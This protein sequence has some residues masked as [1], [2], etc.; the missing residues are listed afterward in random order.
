LKE[1]GLS[2]AKA[3][4]ISE[5]AI[6]LAEK[7]CRELRPLWNSVDNLVFANQVRVLEAFTKERISSAHMAPTTGYGYQDLGRE[8][9]ERLYARIFGAESALVRLH[10]ASGTHVLKTALSAL[11][12]PGEEL[13]ALTGTPYETL[14]PVIH[15]LSE[16]G[17]SYRET[18]ILVD[19]ETGKAD[20]QSLEQRLA[21]EI[22]PSTKVLFIQRSRG[23]SL[24][25]SISLK[26]LRSL[27][28]IT[29]KR[30]PHLFT[31]VDNCYCE[32]VDTAEPPLL[33]AT[34]TLGSLIKNPGGGLAPTGGYVAGKRDA[35]E[36]VAET[37][38][39]PGLSGQVGSNPYG[40]R[41]LYQ[42]LFLAPKV[43]GEALRGA[44]FAALFFQ[45]M[46]Y[47]VDPDPFEERT[48][49]VQSITLNS[50]E[51]LK[52]LTESVQKASPVDSFA[53]PVPWDMPGY[54]HQV[55]MAAGTFIQGSSIELSCDAPFA[56]PYTAYL[57][58]GLTK[59][60]VIIACMAAFDRLKE[61]SLSVH[62]P[63]QPDNLP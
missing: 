54:S 59:E 38:Y 61:M 51:G 63:I 8:G 9:L 15:S 47:P 31:V 28:A 45:K 12:R 29:E 25:K 11:L 62:I 22:Q 46:G 26:T 16:F 58:G 20:Q 56:P 43:V 18:S 6:D 19:F 33:G 57:Q 3:L 27:F 42:G 39:A 53:V 13:L 48:D 32:L 35:V 23:Y 10:W 49:I 4:G 30:W 37:L 1:K 34:L 41:D 55:I 52:A 7:C 5:R 36:K 40:Y 14:H 50:E 21:E 17:V 24:R 44:S 60:H 2:Q